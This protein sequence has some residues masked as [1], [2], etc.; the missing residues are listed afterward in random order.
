[1]ADDLEPPAAEEPAA[2]HRA[3]ARAAA[4]AAADSRTI[5]VSNP[6]K[7]F[8]PADGYTK[9]DLVAYYDAV[10]PLFLPYLKDRPV[11]LTRYPDGID[12]KSFYQKDA[13][14]YVPDWMRTES[15]WSKESERNIRFF[16]L[17]DV[18]SLRYVA[19]LGT[20]PIHMWSSRSGSL[21]RPDWCVLDLDPKGAP[22]AHVVEVARA[23]HDIL[24]ELELPSYPKT[25]GAT[26]LHIL[27]PLG[28]RYTHDECRTFARVLATLGMEAK[29]EI[30]TLARP[31]HAR[32]GRVYIDWGQNGHGITIAAPYALRP[33]PGAPAS[34]P[35]KWSE[36]NGRL[37]P[38]KFTL[39]T[40]PKR[41]AKMEDP[42]RPVMGEGI[43]MGRAIKAIEQRLSRGKG[44]GK[45]PA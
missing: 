30:S 9:G 16:V 11:V 13:P 14:V 38:D 36:V 4:A 15:V 2:P 10:A 31:L 45:G 18:E 41:F 42:L 3:G 34:C 19:N 40:L 23:L 27:I 28:R 17:D 25:S 35:L 29:P 22:F 44:K 1:G 24:D 7:V 33:R 37:D 26:G 39:R 32:G 21:E 8:W 5:R 12:G 43:D 20:I 6:E